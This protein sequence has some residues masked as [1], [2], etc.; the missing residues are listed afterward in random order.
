LEKEPG[1]LTWKRNKEN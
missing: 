1:K